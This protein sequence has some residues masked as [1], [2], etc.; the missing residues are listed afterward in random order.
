MKVFGIDFTSAPRRGKPI[1]CLSCTLRNGALKAE[2]LVNFESFDGFEAALRAS[3][4]WIAGI[5]FPFGQSRK[6]IT[7]IG[8][9]LEWSDYVNYACGLGRAIPSSL[10]QLSGGTPQGGQGAPAGNRYR[11]R[12]H[13]PA[14]DPR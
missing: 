12:R 6:F 11:R 5:D 8:W 1:T 14:K 4:P 13:Q 10:G 2:G 7:T 3:G 9:P